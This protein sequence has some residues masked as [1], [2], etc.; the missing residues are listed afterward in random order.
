MSGT[1]KVMR[2]GSALGKQEL[3]AQ[4]VE[5]RARGLSY[6]KIAKKLKVSKATLANWNHEFE[7]EIASLKA[8]ELEALYEQYH[9]LKES[10]IKLLGKH[11][12]AIQ[13]EIATRDFKEVAL[14]KLLDYQLRY[15]EALN[16]EYVEPHPL[17]HQDKKSL[18]WGASEDE[19]RPKLNSQEIAVEITRVLLRFKTGQSDMNHTSKELAL[20][21]AILKAQEQTGL[22]TK[23]DRLEALLTERQG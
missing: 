1:L 10:R 2:K 21:L 7:A 9:L 5:L 19:T 6:A 14:D 13:A 23:L 11:L 17:S 18:S 15:L 8:M 20:L 22:E 4:F 12:K 3:K 16:K